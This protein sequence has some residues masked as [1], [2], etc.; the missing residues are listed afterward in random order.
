MVGLGKT[1]AGGKGKGKKW[2]KAKA[3]GKS[4][5]AAKAQCALDGHFTRRMVAYTQRRVAARV[6]QTFP[7]CP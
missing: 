7:T 3:A 4:K 5:G 6:A 2:S 1:L